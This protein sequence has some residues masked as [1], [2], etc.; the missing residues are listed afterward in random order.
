[1]SITLGLRFR[2]VDENSRPSANARDAAQRRWTETLAQWP[3][4]V[5]S[6]SGLPSADPPI[7][8]KE[9]RDRASNVPPVDFT[10]VFESGDLADTLFGNSDLVAQLN[11]LVA[12]PYAVHTVG[13]AQVNGTP[14]EIP[15]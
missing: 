7:E 3:G 1:M 11:G 13:Q 14:S 15:S 6:A 12:G 8:R 5:S 9:V 2:P 4:V 10:I